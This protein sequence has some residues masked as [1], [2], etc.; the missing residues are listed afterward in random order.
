[1][2]DELQALEALGVTLPSPAYIFGVVLFG[3]AGFAV[4]RYGKRMSLQATTWIGVVLMLYPY[5]VST[6]WLLYAVGVALCIAA[7]LTARG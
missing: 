3:V 5:V 1:M 7:Y 2:K 4:Y 6:T